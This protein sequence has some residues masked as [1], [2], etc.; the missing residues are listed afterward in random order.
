MKV[1]FFTLG[2]RGDVQPYIAVA[3]QLIELGHE[4]SICTGESFKQLILDNNVDYEYASIDLMAIMQTE[5]G[6]IMYNEALKHPIMLMKYMKQELNPLYKK[7]FNDFYNASK[8]ADILVYHPKAL[9]IQ[10][11]AYS[12]NIPCISMPLIPYATEIEE[13][14]NL[15]ITNKYN[16][17]KS[18]NKFT[19]KITSKVENNNI[20]ELNEFRQEVLKLDKRKPN[21]YN[22]KINNY[23]IPIIYPISK[24]LFGKYNSL[25]KEALV[26]EFAILDDNQNISDETLNFINNGSK[27]IVISFSSLPFKDSQNFLDI[28]NKVSIDTNNRFIIL[29]GT[30][31][32]KIDNENILV[33]S[34]EP[35]QKLLKHAKGFIHHG[36]AGSTGVSLLS[37]VPT[38]IIPF[39]LD[40]P[41]WAKHSYLSG[42]S[43]KP[44]NPK[45]ITLDSMFDRIK[46]FDDQEII[47]NAFKAHEIMTKEIKEKAIVN[48][49][50]KIKN[51]FRGY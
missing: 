43:I 49:I 45:D 34:F 18:I 14:P 19:Y 12:L 42:Y 15:F 46:Q 29:A 31:D 17:T 8:D 3:K 25:N 24:L 41:F 26:C 39:K 20:K 21:I 37:E 47:K 16:F 2:T 9:A 23:K 22:S 5:I 28:I 10:D 32:M 1:V 44:L 30:N 4:A 27:P 6:H 7:T 36:G 11:I 50:I 38:L 51:E 33:T 40:Q 13:F 35:H 48:N